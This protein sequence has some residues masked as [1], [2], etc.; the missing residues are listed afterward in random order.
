MSLKYLTPDEIKTLLWTAMDLKARIKDEG[1]V[2]SSLDHN[3]PIRYRV[4]NVRSILRKKMAQLF[5]SPELK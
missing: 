3:I 2:T 1:Q 4:K 5:L